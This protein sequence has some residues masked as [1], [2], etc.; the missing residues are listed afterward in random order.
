MLHGQMR[1]KESF[2]SFNRLKKRKEKIKC[3]ENNNK[4]Y[5]HIR[6]EINIKI[7][8]DY[9]LFK[10]LSDCM[11]ETLRVIKECPDEVFKNLLK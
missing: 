1:L 2:R 4:S 6:I 10:E 5:L 11:Q 3:R 7:D 9:E 8:A